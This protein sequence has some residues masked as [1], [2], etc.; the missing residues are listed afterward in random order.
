MVC[1]VK[2]YLTHNNTTILYYLRDLLKES[3][4][5]WL[6]D[7]LFILTCVFKS[8]SIVS[9]TSGP[10]IKES[11]LALAAQKLPMS[12]DLSKSYY[13]YRICI[14]YDSLEQ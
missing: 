4:Q 1:K 8:D 12:L 3:K 11:H 14:E 6:H 13:L 5:F 2:L 9:P 10:W 7:F